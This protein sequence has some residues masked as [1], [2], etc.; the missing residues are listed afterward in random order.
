MMQCP[1]RMKR[2][3]IADDSPAVRKSLT[4]ILEG[5]YVVF[6]VEDGQAALACALELKP[7]LIVLDLAMPAMDG[8]TAAREI[9]NVLPE[10]PILMYTMHWAAALELEARKA[11]VRKVF[12]KTQSQDLLAA[13]EELLQTPPETSNIIEPA[14]DPELPL[15]STP[16]AS[17]IVAG[18]EEQS[19]TLPTEPRPTKL[20]S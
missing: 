9:S 8:L 16:P 10:T 14:P 7:D 2:I 6:E 19:R 5:T 3:L 11:G 1:F 17:V 12:S 4:A 20:A 13:M 18:A 15:K